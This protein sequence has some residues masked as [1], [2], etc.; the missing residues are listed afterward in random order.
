M[1]GKQSKKREIQPDGIY[2]S[3]LIT[4]LINYVMLDGKKQVARD[5]VYKAIEII[6]KDTNTTGIEG[7]E[8]ALNNVKPQIEVRSKRVGGSNFQIPVPVSANRQITL[9][10]RWIIDAARSNRGKLT[11]AQA[12]AREI[13]AAYKK[14]GVAFKKKEEVFRMAEANKAFAQFA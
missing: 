8:K 10:F 9:A 6:Q 7:L 5:N 11:F 4:K 2:S 1:R 12:L 14:E 3:T 13:V